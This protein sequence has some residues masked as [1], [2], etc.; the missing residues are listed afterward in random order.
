MNELYPDHCTALLVAGLL[1]DEMPVLKD[2]LGVVRDEKK[3]RRA[4]KPPDRRR[5]ETFFCI[6]MSYVWKGKNSLPKKL[7]KLRNKHELKWLRISMSY[8]R[9]PNLGELLQGDLCSKL[10][11]D[12]ISEDFMDRPCNCCKKLRPN[13]GQCIYHGECRKCITV[14][15]ATCH[16]GHYYIGT[17][18]MTQALMREV[19]P[20]KL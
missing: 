3:S 2:V 7:K 4:K 5:R 18:V 6:G 15:K 13:N 17:S 1:P 20:R 8:H 16:D 12:L 11:E 19:D 10:N 9:F 14:Y